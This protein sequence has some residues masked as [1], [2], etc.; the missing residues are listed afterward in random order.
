MS[1]DKKNAILFGHHLKNQ[2]APWLDQNLATLKTEELK[3]I[4]EI[5]NEDIFSLKLLQF[6][7]QIKINQK[8]DEIENLKEI[9][10]NKL[11]YK[12]NQSF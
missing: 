11:M 2:E 9:I 4:I 7:A 12:L 10:K 8:D 6:E 1:A 3:K 5:Q